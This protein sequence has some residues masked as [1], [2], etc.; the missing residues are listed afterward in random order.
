MG[1]IRYK[2][3][4][5]ISEFIDAIR[6]RVDVFI[7]EQKFEPGWEPDKEDKTSHHYIAI[8]QDRIIATARW[9]ETKPQEVKIERLA[10]S[11]DYR[12]RGVG[13]GLLTYITKDIIRQRPK[14]IWM[15]CQCQKLGF[16][17]SCGFKS[18]SKPFILYG[19]PHIE[20]EYSNL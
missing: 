17:E 1:S 12:G 9:R 11:K 16:Y 2:K 10:V 15:Q 18:S 3:V 4:S 14:R 6:I 19:A 7:K 20:M 13:K 5:S 8:D